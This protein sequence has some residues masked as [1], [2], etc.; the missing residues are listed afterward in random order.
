[1]KLPLLLLLGVGLCGAANCARADAP[2]TGGP[3]YLLQAGDLLLLDVW[4]E[5]ELQSEVLVR[6]DGGISFPLAGDL[7]AAG[8]SVEDLRADLETRLKHYIPD[9]LV[10]V[11]IKAVNGNRVYVIGKVN[12]PGDYMM[13][14]PTD[15]TQA[16][17]LAGGTTPFADTDGI[18]VLRRDASRQTVYLYRYT[19]IEHGR[20]LEQNIVLQGG[21]TVVVP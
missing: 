10:T 4:K 2:A 7:Q 6:P 5:K 12:H 18:K 21:D 8:R 17:A 11:G 1:M 3:V 9:A 14:R 19:D 15:V 13:V 16:I 20:R